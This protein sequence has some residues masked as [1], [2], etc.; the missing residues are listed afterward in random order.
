MNPL[1][2]PRIGVFDAG[3]GGLSV[4]RALKQTLPAARL[5]YVADSGFAPYGERSDEYLIERSRRIAGFL[6][7]QGAQMLVIACNTATAA[8]AR[9]LRSEAPGWPIV[10]VEPGIKPAVA[11]TRNGRIGVLATTST[12]ASEK[13]SRLLHEH[14]QGVQ[15]HAQACPGLAF[16]IEEG[17]LDAPE[18]Q[19]LIERYCA[20]LRGA[21]VDT[22]VLGCTHYPFVAPQIQAALGNEV[23]LIDTAQAVAKRAVSLCESLAIGEASTDST[24]A[25]A[26][27]WTTGDAA[28]LRRI[29]SQW[30]DFAC[31][32]QALPPANL[33]AGR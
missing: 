26:A 29:A 30:L 19:S 16:A 31:R 25:N 3:V 12:L 13:F 23:L 4:L 15:V 6:R 22:V 8:A 7:A 27:L 20:P 28:T 2:S 14:A 10:G 1:S 18:L 24:D 17:R 11:A 9:A 21:G 5:L 32:V 33:C